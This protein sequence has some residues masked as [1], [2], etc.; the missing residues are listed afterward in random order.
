MDDEEDIIEDPI[1]EDST[2]E[3]SELDKFDTVQAKKLLDSIRFLGDIKKFPVHKPNSVVLEKTT[4]QEWVKWYAKTTEWNGRDGTEHEVIRMV[5]DIDSNLRI[6][7]SK[8]EDGFRKMMTV[9][10]RKQ[11]KTK[12]MQNKI[13]ML[14]EEIRL[15]QDKENDEMKK[16]IMLRKNNGIILKDK[17]N[18]STQ[19]DEDED[20]I[21]DENDVVEN[22]NNGGIVE[23]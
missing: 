21:N 11:L 10:D 15:M 19:S 3:N 9:L 8:V 4:M 12:L 16:Q 6:I 20:E 17:K 22:K 7:V 13:D 18:I 5:D 1:D 14:L 23:K 2:I